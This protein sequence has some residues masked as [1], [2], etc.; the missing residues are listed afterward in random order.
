[1]KEIHHMDR[2]TAITHARIFDGERVIDEQTVVF[3][4]ASITAVGGALPAGSSS[5]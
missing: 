2:I 4:G 5:R 1:M 3:N